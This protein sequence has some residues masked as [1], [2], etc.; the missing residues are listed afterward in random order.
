[1]GQWPS[2]RDG[3]RVVT[4]VLP[5]RGYD[6]RFGRPFQGDYSYLADVWAAEYVRATTRPGDGVF[7]WGFEPL[8]YVLSGRRPPT[9]FHFAV[10]LVSPWAPQAW[11]REL[12]RDLAAQPPALF[13]VLQDDA[14]P[15]ASGR[16]D[17][18]RRQLAR[19]PELNAFLRRRYC[20]ERQLEHFSIFRRVRDRESH[21]PGRKEL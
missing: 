17:D 8:V 5:R 4:G 1:V 10:P 19:F 13:L 3:W 12:L 18:S 20:F 6:A 14:I 2:Y 9:R 21:G 11:R 7:I 15:W 16:G